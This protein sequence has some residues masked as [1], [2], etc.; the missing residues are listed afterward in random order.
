MQIIIELFK[1]IVFEPVAIKGLFPPTS[2]HIISFQ[3]HNLDLKLR[4]QQTHLHFPTLR[5]PFLTPD[6]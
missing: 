6:S 4:C 1:Y 2:H 3:T 5:L